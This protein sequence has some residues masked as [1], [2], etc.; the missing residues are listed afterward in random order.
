MSKPID[1][2]K[3]TKA[4]QDAASRVAC[5]MDPQCS[6]KTIKAL[7]DRGVIEWFKVRVGTDSLGAI[8][9]TEYRIP[10]GVHIQWAEWCSREYEAAKARGKA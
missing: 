9:V 8:C 2:D 10:I 7:V 4:Q 5:N 1:F 6:P 3:L